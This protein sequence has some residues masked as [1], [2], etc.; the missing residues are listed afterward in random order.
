MLADHFT[1]SY[2][3]AKEEQ[4]RQKAITLSEF[5]AVES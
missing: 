3:A 5:K 4:R 2:V 1:A